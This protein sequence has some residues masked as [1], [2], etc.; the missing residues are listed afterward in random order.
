MGRFMIKIDKALWSE[1][2]IFHKK[3]MNYTM[4]NVGN[5]KYA[6]FYLYIHKNGELV[7]GASVTYF[8][9]SLHLDRY[10]IKSGEE[11]SGLYDYL[12]H[13][14]EETALNEK[15]DK[16]Y[17][18]AIGNDELDHFKKQGYTVYCVLE[19]RPPGFKCYYLSKIPELRNEV[20]LP[21]YY[22][23]FASETDNDKYNKK[24]TEMIN[25]YQSKKYPDSPYSTY[26][27]VARESDG[28]VI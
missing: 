7:A 26:D 8:W 2:E 14:W 4:R 28:S 5:S 3:F 17:T 15:A 9:N 20:N 18:K 12:L 22:E 10:W 11:E 13:H 21:E 16:I 27:F 6:I 25:Y 23:I 1:K 19:G 24:K